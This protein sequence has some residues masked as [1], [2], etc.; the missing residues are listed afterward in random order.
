MKDRLNDM[1]KRNSF[2]NR[3]DGIRG[4]GAMVACDIVKAD[5]S[6]DAD[7]TKAITAKAGENGLVLLVLRC[8]R[9]RAPLPHA[10]GCAED[11]LIQE[12]FDVLEKTIGQAIEASS[13]SRLRRLQRAATP[14]SGVR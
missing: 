14:L 7:L 8:Q 6:P 1:K 5:G 9:Q 12:G 10:A 3:I 11:K 4:L 13:Q 2:G